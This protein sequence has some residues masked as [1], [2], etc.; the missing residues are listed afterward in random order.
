MDSQGA[1]Q[2]N[3]TFSRALQAIFCQISWV[4]QGIFDDIFV[5]IIITCRSSAC[6]HP[7]SILRFTWNFASVVGKRSCLPHNTWY[8][9]FPPI[10]LIDPPP[11]SYGKQK[12]SSTTRPNIDARTGNLLQNNFSGR[13]AISGLRRVTFQGQRK[14]RVFQSLPGLPGFVG[15]PDATKFNLNSECLEHRYH[16]RKIGQM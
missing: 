4:F 15:H 9:V 13:V 2:S 8:A 12:C 3:E 16:Q 5:K 14:S 6:T 10:N 11:Q 7:H 1:Q